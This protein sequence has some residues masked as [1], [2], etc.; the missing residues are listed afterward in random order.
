LE[1]IEKI[2]KS[3]N[4]K[5]KVKLSSGKLK[6]SRWVTRPW[7]NMK[8]INS[9]KNA[10]VIDK[11]LGRENFTIFSES[12]GQKSNSMILNPNNPFD[13]A[14]V[15]ERSIQ[16]FVGS[17]QEIIY[18]GDEFEETLGNNESESSEQTNFMT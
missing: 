11:E 13:I 3:K 6:I 10:H 1:N 5:F 16:S 15:S 17:N 14:L 7:D 12:E 2:F 8:V 9:K 4:T 18:S